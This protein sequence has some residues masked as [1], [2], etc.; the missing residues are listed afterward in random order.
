MFLG[1]AGE[2][3]GD[4]AGAGAGAGGAVVGAGAGAGGAVVGAGVGF[5]PVVGLLDG[6][7]VPEAE[8]TAVGSSRAVSPNAGDG[9]MGSSRSASSGS[10]ESGFSSEATLGA[11]AAIPGRSVSEAAVNCA[12]VSAR[13]NETTV[14]TAI[15]D[16]T[17]AAA[18][19]R[20]GVRVTGNASRWGSW[21]NDPQ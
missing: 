12:L 17:A 8:F 11:T 9:R 1:L 19:R 21:C 10:T 7:A 5:E 3:D 20:K 16:M 18:T 4:G 15:S 2:G 13:V 6:F 14:A